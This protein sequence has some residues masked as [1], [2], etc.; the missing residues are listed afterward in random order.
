MEEND[1]NVVL[2]W[3]ENLLPLWSQDITIILEN[4]IHNI[5]S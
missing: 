2:N 1:L 4:F 5:I 3:K